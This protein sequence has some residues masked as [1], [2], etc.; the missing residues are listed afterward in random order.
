MIDMLFM[1]VL[2]LLLHMYG[3]KNDILLMAVMPKRRSIKR[4]ACNGISAGLVP[5]D[6]CP[7]K[8]DVK[9]GGRHG[10]ADRS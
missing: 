9:I 3:D 7:S 2:S 10:M 1:L 5:A 8:D 4:W 6:F